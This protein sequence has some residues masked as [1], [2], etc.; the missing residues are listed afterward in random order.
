MKVCRLLIVFSTL[1]VAVDLIDA[2]AWA[3]P[4]NC[5]TEPNI[6][7]H[8]SKI[9]LFT[10]VEHD[11]GNVLLSTLSS[12]YVSIDSE[13]GGV[14]RIMVYSNKDISKAKIS[15]RSRI[16]RADKSTLVVDG[17]GRIFSLGEYSNV[18]EREYITNDYIDVVGVYK[19]RG[20]VVLMAR[21]NGLL[22]TY[23][24]SQSLVWTEKPLPLEFSIN[25]TINS[26]GNE[27]FIME[28]KRLAIFRENGDWF[29]SE[30][31]KGDDGYHLT[32][33]SGVYYVVGSRG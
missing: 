4:G 22:T 10:G 17:E 30:F 7:E 21:K 25:A 2:V 19:V 11:N 14:R 20:G 26:D 3:N 31:E 13:T 6:V 12:H 16:V 8:D 24:K 32:R 33:N 27:V 5:F 29:L 28:S 15:P 23:V 9:F 1:V 18:W